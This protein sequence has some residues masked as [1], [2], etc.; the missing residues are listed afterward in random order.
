MPYCQTTGKLWVALRCIICSHK[1]MNSWFWSAP[2]HV[3]KGGIMVPKLDRYAVLFENM[4]DA[5]ACH[6]IITDESGRPVDYVF[7]KTNFAFRQMT[8]LEEEKI[9]GFKATEIFPDLR[10]SA[11]DW[12]AA[13]GEVALTGKSKRFRHHFKLN[14]HICS[15]TAYSD[16]PGYFTA[17]YH[18]ITLVEPA[19]EDVEERKESKQEHTEDENYK[20]VA[21]LRASGEGQSEE[22]GKL[23]AD[24]RYHDQL[25]GLYNRYYIDQIIKERSSFSN[26]NV[27]V[28]IADINGLRIINNSH[29][30]DAG[31]RV[32]Q[33]AAEVLQE[34][35]SKDS[36]AAHWGGGEFII[37][38]PAQDHDGALA[39]CKKLKESC[40]YVTINDFPLSIS[41]GLAVKNREVISLQDA[42]M[43]AED[44]LVRQKLTEDLSSKRYILKA[45][46]KALEAKSFETE[47]HSRR[48]QEVAINIGR[49]INLS[50]EELSRLELLI[51]LHDI[52]KISIPEEIL[53]KHERLTESEWDLLKKHSETG[54]RI[55]RHS[56]IL[57]HVA[58][59]I[60]Y[61]HEC[62]DGSG[63]PQ[64]LKEDQI[65]L[66][67]RI[68]AI[69]DAFEIMSKGHPYKRALNREEIMLE[70]KKCSGTQFD[71]ALVKVFL[72]LLKDAR[73]DFSGLNIS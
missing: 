42:V 32:I 19:A 15:V 55:V 54:Y 6:R 23:G 3:K 26:M 66:L 45:L 29:G 62:W 46:Q 58:E 50:D 43:E 7:M 72:E 36:L 25:T 47:A 5:C 51:S 34:L 61:H 60:L 56:G 40:R 4:P 63:Y 1:K 17:I 41:C 48:M 20:A 16:S 73:S 14:G 68:T 27:S 52:G 67:A 13:L 9:V 12:L 57:A 37:L 18:N 33:K 64:G 10:E 8:G 59:E 38:L 28:I 31:N 49:K 21:S 39:F 53:T 65:P 2:A 30:Y 24:P 70:F 71:P 44:K 22:T 35:C 11:F 69:A